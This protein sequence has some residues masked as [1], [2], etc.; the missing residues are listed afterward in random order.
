VSANNLQTL[1]HDTINKENGTYTTVFFVKCF[2][3]RIYEH[4]FYGSG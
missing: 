1:E 3:F 2:I 4:L